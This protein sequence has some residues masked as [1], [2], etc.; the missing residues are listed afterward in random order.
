[1]RG[2]TGVGCNL[3]TRI[4]YFSAENSILI[5]QIIGKVWPLESAAQVYFF[6]LFSCGVPFLK[7]ASNASRFVELE[8]TTSLIEQ[9]PTESSIAVTCFF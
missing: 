7:V 8:R 1:M 5:L 9:N 6:L 2:K 3:M 4:D